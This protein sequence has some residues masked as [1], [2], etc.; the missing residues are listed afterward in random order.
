[1]KRVD[2]I[3][4]KDM[5]WPL[6]P[7][8]V[9]CVPMVLAVTMVRMGERRLGHAS[10][11]AALALEI[12]AGAVSFAVAALVLAPSAVGA[13]LGHLRNA[14]GRKPPRRQDAKSENTSAGAPAPER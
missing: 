5:L 14:V 12:V 4:V 7:P 11:G 8:V 10:A 3:V 9:A 2:G 13:L 1:V 6:L